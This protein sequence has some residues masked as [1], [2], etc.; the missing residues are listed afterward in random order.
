MQTLSLCCNYIKLALVGLKI[1]LLLLGPI[2]RQCPPTE[3][4]PRLLPKYCVNF[5]M[6]C[7]LPSGNINPSPLRPPLLLSSLLMYA[8]V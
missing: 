6:R 3:L 2:D 7:I 4:S 8:L 1:L 5:C